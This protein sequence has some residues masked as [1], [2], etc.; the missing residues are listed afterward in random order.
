MT[1][2]ACTDFSEIAENSVNYAGI[3]AKITGSK[4]ILYHSY[5]LP[6]HA[7]NTILPVTSFE[8]LINNTYYKLEK[9]AQSLSKLHDIEVVA[10]CSFS[11]FEDQLA[12]LIKK[13]RATLLVMGMAPKSLEQDLLGNTTSSVIKNIK[14]PVFAVPGGVE[15]NEVKKILFACDTPLLVPPSILKRIKKTAQNLGAEVEI[16]SIEEE[17]NELEANATPN[18]SF[19]NTDTYLEGINY[20]YK[21]V[22]SNTVIETIKKEIQNI[23]ADIL[24]M[25]PRQYG[26]WEALVHR[27][28]T[29]VMASGLSIPLLSLPV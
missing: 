21:N 26:F 10:E 8:K 25:M 11:G 4:L 5:T 29:R 28:K 14:I 22:R 7:S 17:L 2:I 1:I 27:S 3:I 18:E 19:N 20:Y 23:Q 6:L 13:Y 15:F 16:L 12:F 9:R 24:I